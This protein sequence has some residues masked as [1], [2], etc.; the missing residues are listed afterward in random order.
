MVLKKFT[1]WSKSIPHGKK[2]YHMVMWFALTSY[3]THTKCCI[4]CDMPANIG[5]TWS[6]LLLGW[7]LLMPHN[8][9]VTARWQGFLALVTR[10][11][12]YKQSS[13]VRWPGPPDSE[14][15]EIFGLVADLARDD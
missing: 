5:Y 6:I 12:I 10:S 15:T 13:H 11:S 3:M 7:L 2:A 8:S 9:A 14:H 1:A 4:S